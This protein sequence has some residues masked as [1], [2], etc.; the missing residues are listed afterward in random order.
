M[1]I[2]LS[3]IGYAALGHCRAGIQAQDCCE[4]L[5]G[6]ESQQPECYNKLIS[7]I[8]SDCLHRLSLLDSAVPCILASLE[9]HPGLLCQ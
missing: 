9:F 3:G 4:D 6:A 1:R 5:K 7:S 2:E 8:S